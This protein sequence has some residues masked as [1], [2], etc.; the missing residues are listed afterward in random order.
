[1]FYTWNRYSTSINLTN[2]SFKKCNGVIVFFYAKT[3]SCFIFEWVHK[4][5]KLIFLTSSIV[6]VESWA[7]FHILSLQPQ[8]QRIHL[9]NV[10]S[11][12]CLSLRGSSPWKCIPKLFLACG[13]S[14]RLGIHTQDYRGL[15]CTLRSHHTKWCNNAWPVPVSPNHAC[16]R[17]ESGDQTSQQLGK[18][19]IHGVS[20]WHSKHCCSQPL[21]WER[22]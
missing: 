6:K 10:R 21:S 19:V 18:A 4:T 13:M 11:H 20:I 2:H 8:W 14:A 9:H 7:V 12:I 16:P 1:M 15:S 17:H 22:P 5:S 3:Q